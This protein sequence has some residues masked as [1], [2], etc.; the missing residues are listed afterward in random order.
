[1][2]AK[3]VNSGQQQKQA[4]SRGDKASPRDHT[5]FP[6]Y[7]LRNAS[8]LNPSAK[9]S[10]CHLNSLFDSLLA[11]PQAAKA[12]VPQKEPWLAALRLLQASR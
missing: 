3:S 12:N 5:H 9:P 8:P 10:P 4:A 7:D 11:V 1:M 2:G 6:V